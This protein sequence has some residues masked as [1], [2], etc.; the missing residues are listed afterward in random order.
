MY[1]GRSKQIPS[2]KDPIKGLT[3]KQTKLVNQRQTNVNGIIFS[4]KGRTAVWVWVC[5]GA[6]QNNKLVFILRNV[7]WSK[8]TYWKLNKWY[9]GVQNSTWGRKFTGQKLKGKNS[10]LW[11]KWLLGRMKRGEEWPYKMST[12]RDCV[13]QPMLNWS[14]HQ[15]IH[16]LIIWHCIEGLRS[17]CVSG[18]SIPVSNPR[19]RTSQTS[20][21]SRKADIWP[22]VNLEPIKNIAVRGGYSENIDVNRTAK[23]WGEGSRR[24]KAGTAERR[25]W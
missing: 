8:L 20:G 12:V 4:Y 21:Y 22:F 5:G 10:L 2:D 24:R 23:C 19:P 11:E 1:N 14:T 15:V 6:G 9:L 17:L 7:F 25:E 18:F 3:E 16:R 13:N